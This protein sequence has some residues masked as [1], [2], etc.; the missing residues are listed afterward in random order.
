MTQCD[1]QCVRSRDRLQEGVRLTDT[2]TL[3][4]PLVKI[5]EGAS[6]AQQSLLR[7]QQHCS[8]RA[9]WGRRLPGGETHHGVLPASPQIS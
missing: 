7:G 1:L 9:S 6:M 2:T 8:E 3:T 5:E 4:T